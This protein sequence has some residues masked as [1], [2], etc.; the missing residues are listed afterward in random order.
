[1]ILNVLILLLLSFCWSAGYL[2]IAAAE[3]ALPP[4]TTTAAVCGLAAIL[5]LVCVA[6][7]GRPLKATLRQRPVVLALMGLSAISLPQ[8]A[9]I[10][11]QNRI[12]PDVAALVGTVVPVF[13]FLLTAFVLRSRPYSHRRGLGVLTAIAGLAIFLLWDGFEG[14]LG[15]LE[16][17]L[18]MASGGLVFAL[19]GVVAER[20]TR[21]LD[22]LAVGAWA[23]AFGALWMVALALAIEGLPA[24]LPPTPALLGI[25][26]DGL[27]SIG[28]AYLLYFLLLARAGADFTAIYAYVVPVLGVGLAVAVGGE[29]PTLG[30]V[31]GLVVVMLGVWLL[32]GGRRSVAPAA[33]PAAAPSV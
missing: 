27:I 29:Q 18:V 15:S 24:G 11:A 28:L 2:F 33:D 19:N 17:A 20:I 8:L 21:Q 12:G 3:H 22:A 5:L 4:L 23:V 7:L 30:H 13:T 1:M 32:V 25:A 26:G 16:G 9:D 31:L 10:A 14:A 6:A